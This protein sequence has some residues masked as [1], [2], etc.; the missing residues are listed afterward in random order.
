MS[1]QI[2]RGSLVLRFLYSSEVYERRVGVGIASHY[3]GE[4]EDDDHTE[5]EEHDD[6][7]DD[8]F[9]FVLIIVLMITLIVIIFV[10]ITITKTA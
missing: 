1:S 7:A 9:L 2:T 6:E 4:H 5:E 10:I 8:A 3:T